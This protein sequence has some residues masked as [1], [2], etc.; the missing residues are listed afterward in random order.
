MGPDTNPTPKPVEK[1]HARGEFLALRLVAA[2]GVSAVLALVTA[3]GIGMFIGLLT[4][5]PGNA[6][7]ILVS[8]FTH[9]TAVFAGTLLLVAAFLPWFLFSSVKT[10]LASEPAFTHRTVYKVTM[11]GGLAVLA[12]ATGVQLVAAL[13]TVIGSLLTIGVQGVDIGLVYLHKFLPNL[14][15][16]VVTG[17]AAFCFLQTDR[18]RDM[19]KPL[20]LSLASISVVVGLALLIAT[21]VSLHSKDRAVNQF[22]GLPDSTLPTGE[23]QSSDDLP[24]FKED[25][26]DGYSY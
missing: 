12:V 16:A 8:G 13:A 4:G 19:V 21:A 5:T 2:V 26:L 7:E 14:L 17:F 20:S 11:Y 18:G 9:D 3:H 6:L 22:P 15:G 10:S 25:G 24:S 1:K 23:G